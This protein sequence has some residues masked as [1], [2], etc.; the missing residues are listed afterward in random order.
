MLALAAPAFGLDPRLSL[1]QYVHRSWTQGE[2]AQVP[3][4]NALAQT[5]DGYLWLGTNRGL[6]RF[7]GLKFSTP[8]LAGRAADEPI[9][10]LAVSSQGGLWIGTS[11]ALG[12]WAHEH[13]TR[14]N[15][16]DVPAGVVTALLEDRKGVLWFSGAISGKPTFI[17]VDTRNPRVALANEGGLPS[18]AV[19]VTEDSKGAIWIVSEG[20]VYSCSSSAGEYRC[21]VAVTPQSGW[22]LHRS[23][24]KAALHDRDGNLW[25][26]TIGQ[27]LYRVTG[28]TVER[29]TERDGLSSDAILTL[30]ED[31]AGD[32][33]AG[34]ASGIDCFREPRVARWTNAQGL[35]GNLISAV[36]ASHDGD[37]WVATTGGGLDLIGRTRISHLGLATA[38]PRA[39]AIS[40]FEDASHMLWIGTTHGV[41]TLQG[42]TFKVLPAEHGA[43]YDRVLAFAQGHDGTI[44][45]ADMQRGL[46]MVRNNTIAPAHLA[47][48]DGHSIHQLAT[49]RTGHLWIGYAEGGVT[50][51][52]ETAVRTFRTSDGL[53]PGCVQALFEDRTGAMWVGTTKGMSR[54]RHGLWTTWGIENGIPSG[55]VQAFAED[56]R[57]ALWLVT[58]AGVAPIELSALDR[59]PGN[60]SRDTKPGSLTLAFYGPNDGVRMPEIA[61]IMNPRIATSPDGRIWLAT[62]DGLAVL[63][64]KSI[65]RKQRIPPVAIDQVLNDGKLAAASS[66]P[67]INGRSIEIDYTA[68]N[69]ATPEALRFRYRL[70]PL[71]SHWVDAGS[72]RD[73]AYA[74][75]RPGHYRFFVTAHGEDGAWNPNPASID[76]TVDPRFYQTWAFWGLCACGTGLLVYAAHKWRMRLMR[77]RFQ[78]VLRERTRLTRELHDTLLQGFAGVVFQLEAATRQMETQ[79]DASRARIGRALEQADQALREARQALSCLRMPELENNTLPEALKRAAETIVGGSAIRLHM[80]VTGRP[81]ELPYDIQANVFVIAREAVNNAVAHAGADRITITMNYGSDEVTVIVKDD[82]SGFDLDQGRRSDHWGLSGMQERARHI[83]AN[84]AIRSAPGK[85]TEVEV[86]SG[87]TARR[88]VAA[89]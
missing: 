84:L 24:L 37:L 2:A 73:I 4:V 44:W 82:G 66:D 68:L 64:P 77:V 8:A 51:A 48:V 41:E 13:L 20:Q 75:L 45:L 10:A 72:R 70:D 52:G 43:V 18:A 33:W 62:P 83:G 46:A 30:F 16:F 38:L 53:A 67:H 17:A 80:E 11:R 19:S 87:R 36:R 3:A 76:F 55:G 1:H 31:K 42:T 54:F 25:L 57:D 29:F 15:G 35:G 40:L 49:D 5:T 26:G 50:V 32:I 39:D 59:Y 71:D 9:R 86:V 61:G 34:T 85:G 22:G 21:V 7:D 65:R 81:R 6:L 56:D 58:R 12:L 89:D 69:L 60:S 27:G 63:D 14:P 23:L 78:I 79:P 47:G 28:A 74:E 88:R